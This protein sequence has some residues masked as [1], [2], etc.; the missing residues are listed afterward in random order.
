MR[1]LPFELHL[2][3]AQQARHQP[4][5]LAKIKFRARRSG[6]TKGYSKELQASQRLTGALGH[7]LQRVGP[8]RGIALIFQD[9]EAIDHCA[10]RTDEIVANAAHEKAREVDVVHW[11]PPYGFA[12]V[13]M[14]QAS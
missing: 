1:R 2:R 8:H 9:L 3:S 14:F 6:C 7:D 10:H 5:N 13:T 12:T 11:R 4:S